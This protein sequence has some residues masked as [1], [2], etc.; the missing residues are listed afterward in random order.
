LGLDRSEE[1]S[2]ASFA[3]P[4]AGPEMRFELVCVDRALGQVGAAAR[5]AW[6]LRY[7]EGHGLQEVAEL[8]GCS[9]ATVKRRISAA[10][11]AVERELGDT[12]PGDISGES[13]EEAAQ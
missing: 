11:R 10:A 12:L 4:G 9:L 7:V 8:T 2:L 5:S 3:C 6:L 13:A 1:A